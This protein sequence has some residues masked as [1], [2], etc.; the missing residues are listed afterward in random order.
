MILS[1][2]CGTQSIRAILFSLKGEII[3][4]E[5]IFYDAYV[6]PKPGWTEQDPE[7]YWN[8][9]CK[10][11]NTL[12][13]RSPENFKN[14][15]GIGITTL[16]GTMVNLDKDGN[17]LR[18]SI[19][20]L[21]QRMAEN[22]YKPSFLL[23]PIFSALGVNHTLKKMEQKGH[24]NWIRQNQPEL[25]KHTHK[26]LQVS[27]YLNYK[28]SGEFKDSIA[29][30]VGHI[31][32]NYKKQRW[33]KSTD[34]FD[35][36]KKIYP[37]EKEKLSELVKPGQK[38]GEISKEASGLTAIPTGIPLIACGSDK[39]CE[40][41]GM[42]VTNTKMASLSFGTMA[43][44]QTTSK[45]YFEPI[46][47]FPAYTSVVPEHWSP[48]IA[49]FRGFWMIN[50]FKNEF[51]A[52]EVQ[53]A[54]KMN[55]AVEEILNELLYKSPPGAMGLVVQP[56]WSPGLGDKYAKGAMIGFGE[57]HKKEHIYRAV[58]EG[59]AY[60]LFDGMHKLEKRGNVKFEKV[61]LSGGASQSDEICQ[62]M[63]DVFNMP[64]VRGRTHE[65]SALGAAIITAYGIG[66]YSSME[67][68]TE[69]MVYYADTFKPNH[70]NT[71]IYK[72]LFQEVYLKMYSRLEPLYK[73][74][75]EITNYPEV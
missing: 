14:I 4:K 25:W 6:S 9:L 42:G 7:V 64:L 36:S 24:C 68:A 34:L 28:L 23:K 15:K 20:W 59:L 44:V 18:P 35:L 43:T 22:V 46:K 33:S 73:R 54:A 52:K 11:T 72:A 69:N 12:Q 1:I 57:A 63:A 56:Y 53:L 71:K 3:D 21:D 61:A 8:C 27:A 2:D 75:R 47:F 51:A 60:S 45:K 55:V 48:E 40:I 67:V 50:W 29:S 5:Q 32:F 31:P 37:V 58:I 13:K 41:L 70:E 74:I 26:Y 10:A 16:R 19:L 62:I 65:T 30:Q 66:E 49:V 17:I 38:I 39:G